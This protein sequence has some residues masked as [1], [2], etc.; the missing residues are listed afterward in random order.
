MTVTTFIARYEPA[1]ATQLRAA[2]RK[3]RAHFPRGYELVYDNYNALVFAFGPSLKASELVLSLAAYP[4]WVSL[5]FADGKS[6]PDP[7][8]V[9]RG[10]GSQIR[11]VV[12]ESAKHLDAPPVRALIKAAQARSADALKEAPKLSTVIKSVSPK[13]RPRRPSK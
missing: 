3:M 13:Q 5:F 10:S 7:H 9:L 8:K 11:H 6:L 1:L 12:L 4:R 2:R